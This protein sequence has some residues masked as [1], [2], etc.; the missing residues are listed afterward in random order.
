MHP[1]QIAYLA[2]VAAKEALYAQLLPKLEKIDLSTDSPMAYER[3]GR[4]SKSPAITN[5]LAPR[6]MPAK[7]SSPGCSKPSP[8]GRKRPATPPK[9]TPSPTATGI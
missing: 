9:S 3:Y 1:E 7:R 5:L 2:A 8:P 6:M 4:T